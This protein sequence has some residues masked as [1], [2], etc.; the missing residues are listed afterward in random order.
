[1]KLTS[2]FLTR[3]NVIGLVLIIFASLL[4]FSRFGPVESAVQS[5]NRKIENKVPTHVPL[6]I[7]I[8]KDKEE[9]IK[10]NK[11]WYR[12][13]EMEITNTS[14]RPIYY[15]SLFIQMPG[16]TDENDATMIFNVFFGRGELV[17]AN[18]RP[19]P[20]D[21]PLLPKETYTFAI[22]LKNQS[23][24]EAWQKR[25]NKYDVP[26]LE[27]VFNHL[28]FGDGTGFTSTGAVPF[29]VKQDRE[30]LARCLG[31]S[32][33]AERW[34]RSPLDFSA[35]VAAVFE[36]PA[37]FVP[38]KFF[39]EH[40][41]AAGPSI[42]PDI[43]CPGT[44]CNKLRNTLYSCVCDS[45]LSNAATIATTPCSDPIGVCGRERLLASACD[46]GGIGCPQRT[47]DPCSPPPTP[48]PTPS[49]SPTCEST[50]PSN[51]PSGIAKDPCRD[52]EDNGCP[53][54]THPEG[55]CCV[56]D[57]CFYPPLTCPPGKNKMQL[58]VPNCAQFC[59][60]ALILPELACL[61]F[62]F[63]WSFT[64]SACRAAPPVSESDCDAFGW[65]WNP[66]NDYCQSDSP[67]PCNLIP[68]EFCP[69]G[70]WSDEW[71]ACIT[72]TTPIVVDVAGNGFALTNSASGVDFN[73]NK[74][75]G[76]ERLAWTSANSDDG[77]LV[78]D[79]N[80]N[81]TIDDGSELF[82]DLSPQPEP[83]AGIKKNGFLALAEYDKPSN[84]GNADGHIDTR[85][86]AFSSLR[87]WQD[88]NHNGLSES[89]ELHT[90]PS[91][92]VTRFELDYKVS[93]KA[94]VHGNQFGYR[95]KVKNDR[96]QQLGRWAWD[97]YLVRNL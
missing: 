50:S 38:V 41:L 90:L 62:G 4:L 29:P 35:L 44:S 69:Q 60:D 89:D 9:K 8:K 15:F 64:A 96:G 51:C 80:G 57:S 42:T 34:A 24:W 37:P 78:L 97:V 45:E 77:W 2:E 11:Q 70:P 71:C 27:I 31:K 76:K 91:L 86:A 25:H 55:A 49:P 33:P 95:A 20:D 13:F 85:D 66:I 16:V 53:L 1:M 5:V 22:P 84:G 18:T 88:K 6:N 3:R 36:T 61:E 7:K 63:L 21:K 40:L 87:L 82:G 72:Y 30:E 28:S 92:D 48:S 83:P 14:E 10:S 12:D 59:V 74:I 26:K 58:G 94:D 65:F 67:P 54:F 73:L 43:C 47:F 75:G 56:E 93:K 19:L 39:R 68:P 17:D 79:R 52:P 46:L 32:P 23:A 81:N